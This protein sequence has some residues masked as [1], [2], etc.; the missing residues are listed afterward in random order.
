MR[1]AEIAVY[2]VH[3]SRNPE[4]YFFLLDFEEFVARSES[5]I[6]VRPALRIFSGRDDFSRTQFAR[7][8]REVFAAEF[9]RMR[10][11]LASGKGKRGWLDWKFAGASA[12]DL[13]GGLVANLV[14]AVALSIGQRVVGSLSIPKLFTGK[15]PEAKLAD[16]I[17]DTKSRVEAALARVDVTIYPELFDHACREGRLGRIADMDRDAWPLPA[18]VRTHLDAGETTAWW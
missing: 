13:V 2:L 15:A 7:Q 12:L 3:D 11:D 10:T 6:F 17:E 9:D 5:G 18:F 16:K 14:L 1:E 4:D 8:F